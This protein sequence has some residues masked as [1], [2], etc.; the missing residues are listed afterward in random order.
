[1]KSKSFK[2]DPLEVL[3]EM[4]VKVRALAKKHTKYAEVESSFHDGVG[5]IQVNSP[6][7]LASEIVSL[8]DKNPHFYLI[9]AKECAG[10][11][12][13]AADFYI[14]DCSLVSFNLKP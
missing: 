9:E 6:N 4:E 7:Q 10:Q 3:Q 12:D 11:Y 14:K 5:Y 2:F 8:L 13:W 1:M